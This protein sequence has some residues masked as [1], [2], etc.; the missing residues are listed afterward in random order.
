M[1][2]IT[3]QMGKYMLHFEGY[4]YRKGTASANRQ[5]WRCTHKTC[6]GSASTSINYREVRDVKLKGKHN[7]CPSPGQLASKAAVENML[8]AAADSHAPPRR[9]LADGVA[10]LSMEA[11]THLPCRS[12][13]SARL[14][15][16]RRR[17]D[18]GLP[19]EPTSLDNLDIP[20]EY[21][22]V[23]HDN[24]AVRFLLHNEVEPEIRIIVFATDD[25]LRQVEQATTLM[26]DGTFK[27][28]PRLFFQ[29]YVIHAI[30]DN[31]TFP[32]A[33]AVTW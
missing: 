31:Y 24:N 32:C 12:T 7:H 16:K 33:Y 30:R 10:G 5:T 11:I 3:L 14:R 15:R 29:L 9:I 20:E 23:K 17:V 18:G 8:T 22:T 2:I 25:M 26:C 4:R 1:E 27:V 6:R 13:I 19:P 28:A 21:R